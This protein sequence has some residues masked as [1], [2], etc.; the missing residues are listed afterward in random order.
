MDLEII[1]NISTNGTFDPSTSYHLNRNHHVDTLIT[2]FGL[3]SVIASILIIFIFRR[4]QVL[5]TRTNAYVTNLCVSNILYLLFSPLFLNLFGIAEIVQ[6]EEICIVDES[7]MLLLL[8]LFVFATVLLLDWYIITYKSYNVS[9]RCKSSYT[10]IIATIWLIFISFFITICLQ[11]ASGISVFPIITIIGAFFYLY[12]FIFVFLI[13]IARLFKFANPNAIQGELE[14]ELEIGTLFCMCW[15]PNCAMYVSYVFGLRYSL[16]LE[17]F[18]YCIAHTYPIILFTLLY[19]KDGNF[20][21]CCR[22]LFKNER[23]ET[24]SEEIGTDR[25]GG[26]QRFTLF[27]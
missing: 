25:S 6:A 12:F 5:H 21:I 17:L 19:Y 26:K 4:Y 24:E 27:I 20:R 10:L 7:L 22:N 3:G 1:D 23:L 13:H 14:L 2:I 8:S 11:C 15:M 16:D 9:V 18:T